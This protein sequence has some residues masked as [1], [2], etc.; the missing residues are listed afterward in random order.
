MLTDKEI[1]EKY[2]DINFR[3]AFT[4]ARTFQ[5]FLKTDLNEDIGL[6]QIYNIL[7]AQPF[8]LM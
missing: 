8:Y 5:M 3:G 6:K 1:A 4:G 2:C 7:K